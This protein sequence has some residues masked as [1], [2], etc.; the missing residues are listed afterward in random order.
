MQRK[1]K[2]KKKWRGSY[3]LPKLTL[4]M[5]NRGVGDKMLLKTTSSQKTG[6]DNLTGE[7]LKTFKK[8]FV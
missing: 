3:T 2:T 8:L 6:A 4:E 7:F 5:K 1:I